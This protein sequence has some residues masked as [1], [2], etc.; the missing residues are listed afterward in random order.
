MLLPCSHRA[1]LL[2]GVT[3]FV[4]SLPSSVSELLAVVS[5]APVVAQVPSAR[6][7]LPA[8]VSPAAGGGTRPFA[9]PAPAS[10]TT[11]GSNAATCAAVR[12]SGSP[13]APVLLPF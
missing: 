9:P 7:N 8:A 10:P 5:D 11:A 1:A 12:S 4:V 2:S 3:A 6:R 13:A